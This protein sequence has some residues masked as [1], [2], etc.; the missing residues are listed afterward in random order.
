[1]SIFAVVG[2]GPVGA[3]IAH[4][5]A[6]A[7][8]ARRVVLIDD[9]TDVARGLALDIRQAGPLVGSSAA[10]EGTAD[11]G[12]VIGAAVVV[13]ADRH[14]AA[15]DWRGDDGLAVVTRV[16]ELNPD[17]LI[18]CPGAS[19]TDLVETLV[20][21]RD[22]DRR[23]LAGS[24]PEALR[25]AMT[26]LACLETG[27]A[28]ADVS[29]IAIGRPPTDLFVPWDGASI[30]GSRATDVI[31]TA[32]LARLDRQLPHLWP[33]GPLALAAAATR[34]VRLALWRA[35]GWVCLWLVPPAAFGVR[36]RGVAVPAIVADGVVEPVW[37]V[38]PTR[39]RVRLDSV[40]AG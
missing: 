16:R 12:A 35:P 13:I 40:L 28:P 39:D 19:Q 29:L 37:P 17:A 9:A 24:A 21:E 23:R 33:P 30:G 36:A 4:Q 6:G 27:T 8:L 5:A 15:G 34:V 1:M 22:M 10:V 38:L 14:G 3:A 18:I 26:A 7:S 25:S 2:A 20:R 31:P 11:L 32:V